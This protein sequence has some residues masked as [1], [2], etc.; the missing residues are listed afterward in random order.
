[1]RGAAYCDRQ[2]GLV[3]EQSPDTERLIWRFALEDCLN[4]TVGENGQKGWRLPSIPELASL[5]STNSPTCNAGAG[6]VCLPKGH[7]FDQVELEFYWSA[8]T[9]AASTTDSAW[10]VNME[11]GNV[12]RF[13][14]DDPTHEFGAWCVRGAMSAD[15]Y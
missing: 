9:S 5:I 14:V 3:W 10:L 8:T 6:S 12:S 15:A 11:D 4:R 2:T 7:P 13:G 1:M